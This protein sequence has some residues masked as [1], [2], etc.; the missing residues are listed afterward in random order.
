LRRRDEQNK[1][2]DARLES[3]SAATTATPGAGETPF[4]CAHDKSALRRSQR[5]RS[6]VGLKT[7]SLP[8]FVRAGRMS[9]LARWKRDPS[10]D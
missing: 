2:R 5:E 1:G 8:S 4:D 10:T 3:E 6:F 7:P 9:M